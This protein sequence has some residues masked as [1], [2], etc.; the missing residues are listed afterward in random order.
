MFYEE[1]NQQ[2]YKVSMNTKFALDIDPDD[3]SPGTRVVALPL[4]LVPK[5]LVLIGPTVKIG[6]YVLFTVLERGGIGAAYLVASSNVLKP[7][8]L[9]VPLYNPNPVDTICPLGNLY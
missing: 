8:L 4:G 9:T 2:I 1:F 6:M 3:V 5:K 7:I